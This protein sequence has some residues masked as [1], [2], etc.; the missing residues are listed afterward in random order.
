MEGCKKLDST[1][2]V[3]GCQKIVSRALKTISKDK[4]RLR[5]VM[6]LLNSLGRK[7]ILTDLDCTRSRLKKF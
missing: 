7:N 3:V 2:T 5:I 1:K 4:M 6:P